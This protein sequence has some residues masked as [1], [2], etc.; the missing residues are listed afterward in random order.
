MRKESDAFYMLRFVIWTV[1]IELMA[2]VW[3]MR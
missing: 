1:A 2:L 3:W